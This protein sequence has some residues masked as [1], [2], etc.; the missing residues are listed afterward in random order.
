MKKKLSKTQIK[1]IQKIDEINKKNFWCAD[2]TMLERLYCGSRS[3]VIPDIERF[4]DKVIKQCHKWQIICAVFCESDGERYY[5]AFHF[6]SYGRI[7]ELQPD[8]NKHADSLIA[9]QNHNHFVSWGWWASPAGDID[10]TKEEEAVIQMF[11]E[12]G[13]WNRDIC[14]VNMAIR[15]KPTEKQNV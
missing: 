6:E 12:Y 8:V 10:L 4:I 9:S 13:A 11:D 5:K 2:G 15:S 3:V 14:S 1:R 7:K